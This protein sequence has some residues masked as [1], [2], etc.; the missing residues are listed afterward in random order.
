MPFKSNPDGSLDLYIQN[1]SAG[2]EKE[3]NWLPAPKDA[4]N[5]AMRLYAPEIGCAHRRAEPACGDPRA[6]AS[7]GR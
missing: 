5:L 7:V 4:F 2:A 3:A 1:Q 6:G